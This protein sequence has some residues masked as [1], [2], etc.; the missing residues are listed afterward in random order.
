M[1]VNGYG[2]GVRHQ[3]SVKIWTKF[4]QIADES[5]RQ[6][7]LSLPTSFYLEPEDVNRLKA[8]ARELLSTSAEFQRLV[9]DLR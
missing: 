4:E 1:F 2:S 9:S 7:L 6:H 5:E 3:A 8:A